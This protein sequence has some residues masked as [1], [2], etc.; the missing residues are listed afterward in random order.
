MTLTSIFQVKHF[1]PPPRLYALMAQ[2][3]LMRLIYRRFVSDLAEGLPPGTRLLDVGTG[4]GY[5]L[6]YLARVRPDLNLWGADFSYGMISRAR[7]RQQALAP[8]ASPRWLVADACLLPFP[9][10][11]FGHVVSTFS[12]H[13]WPCPVTGLKELLRVLK[14]GGRAWVYEL[15]RQASLRD[16]QTFA[17][18]T[19]L[20]YLFVYLGYQTVRWQHAWRERELDQA[21]QQAAGGRRTLRPAHHLFWRAELQAA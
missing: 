19:G 6:G 20:P 18:Q 12:F 5:L 1:E 4:P 9:D 8:Q 2:S 17:R 13:I 16:L 10:G 21:L 7:P 3:S 11:V 14:P 15:R